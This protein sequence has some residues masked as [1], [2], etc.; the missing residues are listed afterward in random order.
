M[1]VY[2]ALDLES[3]EEYGMGFKVSGVLG[4]VLTGEIEVNSVEHRAAWQA[5]YASFS[6]VDKWLLCND[7]E[8]SFRKGNRANP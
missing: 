8:H 4:H 7:D 5:L 1:R 2:I 3:L 6:D